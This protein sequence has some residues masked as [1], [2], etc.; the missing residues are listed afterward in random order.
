M[1]IQM[2]PVGL[3]KPEAGVTAARPATEPVMMPRMV[4]RPL[5]IHSINAQARPAA[6][7]ARW[8]QRTRAATAPAPS[9]LPA[10]KPNSRTRAGRRRGR[11]GQVVRRCHVVRVAEAP[12]SISAATSAAM[13]R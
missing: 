9:A 4:G 6:E 5:C 7:P 1:P 10:L 2:A 11:E 13:P 12:P 8:L 3:T